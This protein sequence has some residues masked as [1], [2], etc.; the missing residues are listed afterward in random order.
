[1][2]ELHDLSSFTCTADVSYNS[3]SLEAVSVAERTLQAHWP[4]PTNQVKLDAL[5]CYICSFTVGTKIIRHILLQP[6]KLDSCIH[7]DLKNDLTYAP[8]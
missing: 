2:Q 4:K 7:S 3:G 5:L 6:Q 1:M 8:S